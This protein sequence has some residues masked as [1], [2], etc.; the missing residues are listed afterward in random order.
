MNESIKAIEILLDKIENNYW[1]TSDDIDAI[2]GYLNVIKGV[3]DES[4]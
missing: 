4:R 3:V 1:R 2:R